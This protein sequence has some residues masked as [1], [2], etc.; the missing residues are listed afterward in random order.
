L[1][2]L[3]CS[4]S[5]TRFNQIWAAPGSAATVAHSPGSCADWLGS[6]LAAAGGGSI[7]AKP[8]TGEN[9]FLRWVIHDDAELLRPGAQPRDS[10]R[11]SI[12]DTPCAETLDQLE[13]RLSWTYN[14]LPAT[15]NAAKTSVSSF[16]RHVAELSEEST[17]FPSS[18]ARQ[19]GRSASVGQ[20]NKSERLGGAETG[21]AYHA[22][23]ES[24]SLDRV[25]STEELKN[26]AQRLLR[27]GALS[28]SE[29][30]L[31]DFDLLAAFWNSDP[32]LQIRAQAVHVRRELPFTARF[33]PDELGT[34]AG[35]A[36]EPRLTNEFVV[37]Q[38]VADL[39]VVLPAEIWLLDFK[40]DTTE[41][42]DGRHYDTQ[43][44]LYAL[45]LERIYRRPVS[46]RWIYFL[47]R[48]RA[49]AV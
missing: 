46:R 36:I 32:G 25:G 12:P 34:L 42:M 26:E 37:V 44:K 23:L 20:T 45:A 47:T 4:L 8:G 9:S 38:G 18:P 15:R 43:L 3:S 7:D 35:E 13:K 22:F 49:I 39:V 2:L 48:Q 30:V 16:R 29:V 21:T 41:D 6:W 33:S 31:L 10:A 14:Y 27:A 28:Q 24:V 19:V 40:T 11:A 1:L 5:K 17:S